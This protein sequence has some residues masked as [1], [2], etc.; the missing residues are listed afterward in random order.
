MK[1]AIRP[2]EPEQ[3]T[4]EAPRLL[5]VALTIGLLAAAL[6]LLV[7]SWLGREI[8]TG[9][10]PA[11]D[12][13]LRE[14]VRDYASPWLTQLMIAVSRYG[15]PS[16]LVP[17]GIVLALGFFVRR[18]PRGAVLVLVTMAGAGLLNWLL[19]Q[20]FA[21]ERP[22]A[23]F[24]DYPIPTS[25]S[26]PS[27][28]AFFAASFLGGV[29][30]LLSGRVRSPALRAI[31]WIATVGLIFLIGFSRVYLGVH[32]PSDVFAGYAAAI[33]WVAA[34]ALGDRLVSHRRRRVL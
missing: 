11:A 7:F 8:S 6:A 12:Q 34:V 10:T 18:W 5:T 27:G 30:A 9:V 32:Y 14:A 25:P 23:F 15:G 28:H 26:F 20:T 22:V 4:A 13:D 17:I 2:A 1:R 24:P 16:W 31:I 3:A 33:V 21:R 29:A 19:K